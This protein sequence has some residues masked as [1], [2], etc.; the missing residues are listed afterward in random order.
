[1]DRAES[2]MATALATH[3]LLYSRKNILEVGTSQMKEMLEVAGKILPKLPRLT[4]RRK[5][6]GP[7][8]KQ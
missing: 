6:K 7:A 8:Y 2:R 4:L 3:L 5:K 1:M